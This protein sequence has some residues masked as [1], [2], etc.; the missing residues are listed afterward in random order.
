MDRSKG[1]SHNP[2]SS[3]HFSRSKSSLQMIPINK[4]STQ[5]MNRPTHKWTNYQTNQPKNQWTNQPMTQPTNQW[6]NQ[7]TMTQLMT[8]PTNQWPNKP[9]NEWTNK[10]TN[11]P[12]NQSVNQPI[13][14]SKISHSNV[15]FK[16]IFRTEDKQILIEYDIRKPPLSRLWLHQTADWP[17]KAEDVHLLHMSEELNSHPRYHRQKSSSILGC[18]TP[19]NNFK[20]N[21]HLS[22]SRIGWFTL[23]HILS[24][25]VSYLNYF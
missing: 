7:P 3:S 4:P 5:P 19:K 22:N 10:R 11:E 16:M 20:I 13:N 15:S 12:T 2:P 14:Q 25:L 23:I 6:P 21:T 18:W 24:T 9:Y 8:Q 17:S 1:S